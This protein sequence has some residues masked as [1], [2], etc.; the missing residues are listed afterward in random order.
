MLRDFMTVML[1]GKRRAGG[2][3]GMCVKVLVCVLCLASCKAEVK[4]TAVDSDPEFEDGRIWYYADGTA[5]VLTHDGVEATMKSAKVAS[6]LTRYRG[7]RT[8]RMSLR[9]MYDIDGLA[10][11]QP[12]AEQLYAKGIKIAV[13]GNDEILEYM[14]IPE[15]RC[16]KIYDCS[17]GRYRFEL[18]CNP[19]SYEKK[20]PN[21]SITGNVEL[22]EKWI[23]MFDG[24]GVAL[25]PFRMPYA[26]AER[27]AFAAW[28]TG[29]GQFSILNVNGLYVVVIPEGSR[30]SDVYPGQTAYEVASRLQRKVS[31]DYFDKGGRISRPQVLYNA[32]SQF[33]NVTDVVRTPDE[34]ILV[35]EAWQ[36]ANAWLTAAC[37]DELHVDGRTYRATGHEGM[38]GF[39]QTH[40]WS[41]IN[42]FYIMNE[43][44][45]P[46]PEGTLTVDMY[47]TETQSLVMKGLQVSDGVRVGEGIS[48]RKYSDYVQGLYFNP[49]STDS[50]SVLLERIDF[51]DKETVL[52][53]SMIINRP[54]SFPGHIGSDF[55]LTM[56]NGNVLRPVS[57]NSVPVD[58]DFDRHGDHV[59]TSFQLVFP[60]VADDD[61]SCGDNILTGTVCHKPVR[62]CINEADTVPLEPEVPEIVIRIREAM[63]HVNQTNVETDKVIQQSIIRNIPFDSK[64]KTTDR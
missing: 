34:T 53:M 17:D 11:V 39:D 12:Y 27:M 1:D 19:S 54:R 18:N 33:V 25:S 8:T 61:W 52:Y 20:Y 49:D 57:I 45:P 63:Q 48:S 35:Y 50:N 2:F 60:P 30:L 41:P 14:N 26:D 59:Q 37:G 55:T 44:F 46:L 62:F 16:A 9:F 6:Y 22:M 13:A 42:G 21:L 29:K 32:M 28:N 43:H 10:D 36:D 58:Q 64:D 38:D 47:D 23:S 5:R 40:F 31:S 4:Q 56:A 15:C 3:A 51:S 24:H 7:C